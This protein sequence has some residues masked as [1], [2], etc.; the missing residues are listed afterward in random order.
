MARSGDA[1]QTPGCLGRLY[2]RN[3]YPA[4]AGGQIQYLACDTCRK[5]PERNK[6]ILQEQHVRRRAR[7]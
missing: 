7:R 6:V 4:E 2:V 1:C 5:S 3:S